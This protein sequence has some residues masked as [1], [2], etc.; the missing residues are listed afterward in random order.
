MDI[1]AAGV[2]ISLF[3]YIVV[4][5]YAGRK[6]RRLE[7][8]FVAG[9]RAPTLLILGTLIASV[10]STGIFL[11]E[12]GFS[13]SG[14]LGM[15]ILGLPLTSIGYVLGAVYFGRF[16]RR[17]RVLTVAEYFGLR[18][19]SRRVRTAAAITLIIGL[20]GYLMVVT[21]GVALV[22]GQ[23]TGLPHWAALC[24]A[25]LGYTL[26]TLY[27]GSRGVVIT[28]TIMF[29]LFTF[30][31][32]VALYYVI[33][34]SGG[35]FT[36]IDRMA[37]LESRPEL[38][39]WHGLTGPGAEWATPLEAFIWY[40]TLSVAWGIVSAVS[41]WQSSR[42]LMAKDEHVVIRSACIATV[43]LI[44]LQHV[45]Y[46]V[47]GTITLGND[48]I[49]PPDQAIMWAAFNMMPA[50]AGSLLLAGILAA[51]LS[52]AST[53][54]SL[55][56]FSVSYDLGE[57]ASLDDRQM[58]RLSRL[59]MF[60]VGIVALVIAL[61][62]PPNIFWITW[63]VATVFASSWGPVA[64]LSVWSDRVTAAGA[65][66]GIVSGFLGNVLSK[67]AD[68]LGIID[69]PGYFDPVF[70]GGVIS[71][72]VVLLV[73]RRGTVPEEAKRLRRKLHEVPPEDLDPVRTRNTLLAAKLLIA[74][75]F[76]SPVMIL[77]LYVRPYHQAIGR[78]GEGQWLDWSS[79]D[80]ILPLIGA[81]I[82]LTAGL[83]SHRAVHKAYAR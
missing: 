21:Q 3:V 74:Y 38:L 36:A 83:V 34:L 76:I 11:G 39:S 58:L 29:L 68:V 23:I 49:D 8:Y 50:L 72:A 28:D 78:L 82:I 48:A 73:S 71:L 25:W 14:Y 2:F 31:A 17:C 46:Y 26:F 81:T 63:F 19:G 52:S 53:F 79:F 41:P 12:V 27:A 64:L 45:V 32:F 59:L 7:D 62:T 57:H 60:G 70:I 40:T 30:V 77:T 20:G 44:V 9:R 5:N 67:L 24:M 22:L 66:W 37:S 51:G 43:T 54:M 33:E 69:L 15:M 56:G 18:F 10:N 75:A 55:V 35:W 61:L 4:G 1:Y 47:G 42:Y 6:V 65:F 80:T 13:Y 16:L